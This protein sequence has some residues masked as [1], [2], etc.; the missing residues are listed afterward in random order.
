MKRNTILKTLTVAILG[1][2]ALQVQAQGIYVNKKNGE[3]IAYPKAIL[4][5]VS[6]YMLK[7]STTTETLETGAVATL[8][9]EKIADMKTA[10][11]GHQIFPSGNGFV[12][13]GGHTTNFELTSTAEIYENGQWKSIS[14]NNPHDGAFA[15][16][17]SDGR[18][19]VGGGFS[20]KNGVGQSK[21]T[22]IYNPSTKSF[23]AGPDMTVARAA[24]KAIA[25]GNEVYVSGNWYADDKVLDCYD[26]SSF[27]ALGDMDGRSCPYL[28]SD[29]QGNVYSLSAYNTT[30]SDFGFF[31]SSDGDKALSGDMYDVAENKTYYYR[32]WFYSQWVPLNLPYEARVE[33]N[34][35]YDGS[36]NYVVLT[37]NGDQYLLTEPCPDDNKTYN[38][39][40]FSIP[41]R[42]P[43]TN[44]AI[45]YRGTVYNN[46]ARGEYYLIGSSGTSSNQ[47][48][49]IISFSY[50]TGYWTIA[51]ASGFSHDLMS[52]AWTLLSDGR[53][54]CTGGGISSN[55]DAQKTSYIFTPPVA[56]AGAASSETTTEF[57]VDVYKK[58]GNYDR[59]LEKDLESI[60]TYEEHFDER[61]TQEIPT[62]YLSKMSAYMPIYSGNTPPNIEGT[63]SM[64]P[65]VLV[66]DSNNAFN[67]GYKFTDVVIEFT[68][69][70]MT[71][72][73][74]VFRDE[75]VD[76]SGNPTSTSTKSE[77][78]IIGS[79]NDFTIFV[80]A[81]NNGTNGS[82][83]K[84]ASLY[85]GTI[86]NNGIKNF[87]E[88]FVM[89]DK[90]DPDN[91]LMKIGQ[92]RI[93]NDQD[94]MSDTTTWKAR[95]R[96]AR[97]KDG[98]AKIQFLPLPIDAGPT[99]LKNIIDL[100]EKVS[101]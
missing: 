11:M 41:S 10:R 96:A 89:L 23:T 3:N 81:E 59:Y 12:V 61:I 51:S 32:Y 62:E 28:F 26:G 99:G 68:N 83:T 27:K 20:S 90:I 45:S 31:T 56:G 55:N 84:L 22:D 72:N 79:G 36:N 49:H 7:T 88:G 33:D 77:A 25:I 43:V 82:W 57:G 37:K 67:P 9:Y 19:M 53:L 14:I 48:V 65:C 39:N 101:K 66:Y 100:M 78:K 6:P 40:Q 69:Q 29:K 97:I 1:T 30:G 42:H 8:Q 95:Q 86:T 2:A 38:W 85:S 16:T 4:D 75:Y 44:A 60:T 58:D 98:K 17:L 15:V 13:V 34:A 80:I 63:Y 87:H 5:H 73:T 93:V 76:N 21:K 50:Q 70:N 35:Y 24:C 64:S 46:K 18:V 54:A 91:N 92:F 94:G 71:Q 52:G 74:L 47:T